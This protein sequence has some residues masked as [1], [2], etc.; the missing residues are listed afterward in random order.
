M[1]LLNF[2]SCLLKPPS[3]LAYH[4]KQFQFQVAET[5]RPCGRASCSAKGESFDP[6]GSSPSFSREPGT[7][8]L[9]CRKSNT[10]QPQQLCIRSSPGKIRTNSIEKKTRLTMPTR[11]ACHNFL[12]RQGASS[13]RRNEG[14][15]SRTHQ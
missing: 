8:S 2:E 4:S 1:K 14:K 15:H 10:Q 5:G 9:I 3:N 12:D 13:C 7:S 11:L 6:L